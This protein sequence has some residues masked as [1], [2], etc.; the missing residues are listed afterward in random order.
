M[1]QD[2]DSSIADKCLICLESALINLTFSLM[3]GLSN[4]DKDMKV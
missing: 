2:K 4:E 3:I 1:R